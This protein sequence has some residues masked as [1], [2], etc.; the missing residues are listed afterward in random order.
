MLT[1]YECKNCGDAGGSIRI[2]FSFKL[3]SDAACNDAP[4][5]STGSQI[6]EHYPQI[7][8][9]LNHVTIIGQLFVN[10]NGDVMPTKRSRSLKCLYLWRCGQLRYSL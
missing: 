7:T 6:P 2:V 4:A 8:Q 1:R 3:T 5:H 9:S 10:C